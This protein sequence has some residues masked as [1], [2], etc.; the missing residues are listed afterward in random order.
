MY[1]QIIARNI[2]YLRK[3]HNLTKAAMAQLLGICVRGLSRLESGELPPRMSIN[4]LY[5]ISYIFHVKSHDL[6]SVLLENQ[7]AFHEQTPF[8]H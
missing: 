1:K 8:S 7:P 2:L 6:F 4:V 3:K 5:R